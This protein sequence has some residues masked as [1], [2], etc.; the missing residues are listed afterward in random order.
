MD[1]TKQF[2]NV[3]IMLSNGKRGPDVV[4]LAGVLVPLRQLPQPA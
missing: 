2:G 4:C 1:S 3:G